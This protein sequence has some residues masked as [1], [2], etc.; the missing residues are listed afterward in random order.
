MQARAFPARLAAL[1]YHISKH[2]FNGPWLSEQEVEGLMKLVPFDGPNNL[3][4]KH[5][6]LA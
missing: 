6:D 5:V 4:L 3:Y 1:G 2:S